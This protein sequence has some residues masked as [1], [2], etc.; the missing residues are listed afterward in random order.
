MKKIIITTLIILVIGIIIEIFLSIISSN[1]FN[2]LS[3]N[4]TTYDDQSAGGLGII[5]ALTFIQSLR[6]GIA[7]IFLAIILIIWTVFAIIKIVKKKRKKA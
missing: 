4:T 5:I 3:S 1:Q 6:M 2:E 7:I